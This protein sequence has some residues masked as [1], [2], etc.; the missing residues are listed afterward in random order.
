VPLWLR[1]FIGK[2]RSQ[3]INVLY[4]PVKSVLYPCLHPSETRVAL[5]MGATAET[6]DPCYRSCPP[7]P[8]KVGSA[9]TVG[10]Y[11]AADIGGDGDDDG[12]ITEPDDAGCR[13]KDM[14]LVNES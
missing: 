14:F 11:R 8:A 5:P 12:G 7:R 2:S 9:G 3:S 13:G 4:V 6:L 1:L 10:S